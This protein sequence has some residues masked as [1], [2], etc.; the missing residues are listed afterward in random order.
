MWKVGTTTPS[1]SSLPPPPP[2]K[3]N[4][5]TTVCFQ[6]PQP[7]MPRYSPTQNTTET[8]ANTR[9]SSRRSATASAAATD[10]HGSTGEPMLKGGLVARPVHP[11]NASMPMQ[12]SRATMIS[13]WASGAVRHLR[14]ILVCSPSAQRLGTSEHLTKHLPSVG[15]VGWMVVVASRRCFVLL[16][17]LP[18]RSMNMQ[19]GPQSQS[20]NNPSRSALQQFHGG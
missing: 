2:S 17:L 18:S 14:R 9:D 19:V 3:T 11:P 4:P 8:S 5:I 10:M 16:H 6:G 12:L 15:L 7:S 13:R 20:Y 1:P